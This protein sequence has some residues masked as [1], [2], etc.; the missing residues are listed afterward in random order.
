[1]VD[2]ELSKFLYNIRDEIKNNYNKLIEEARKEIYT[3]KYSD[4]KNLHY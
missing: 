4:I 3:N 2:T 1:M